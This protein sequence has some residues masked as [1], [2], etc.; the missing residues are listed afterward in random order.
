MKHFSKIF[1]LQAL[2]DRNKFEKMLF[3]C[4]GTIPDGLKAHLGTL[5]VISKKKAHLK[6]KATPDL[7]RICLWA[8]KT[9]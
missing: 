9:V 7:G 8:I 1:K 4:H 2:D 5:K 3:N 6:Y